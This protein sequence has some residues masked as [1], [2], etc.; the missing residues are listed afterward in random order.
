MINKNLQ[1]YIE[2]KILPRYNNFDKGHRIDHAQKVIA[3]SLI[4][5]ADYDVNIDM[6]YAI[7]AYH[8]LG[9]EHERELHHIY[10]GKIL[11]ADE[12]L[13]QW[14]NNEQ[15]EI[16]QMAVEDHRASN[17]HKPRSIYGKIV[18]E[19][20]RDISPQTIIRRTIQYG[21]KKNADADFEFH[22]NRAITHIKEKYGRNGYLKLYLHSEKNERGLEEI[23]KI[24]DDENTLR[25]MCKHFFDIEKNL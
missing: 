4:L 24:I 17:K 14:F 3:D 15:M 10:S 2:T 19:A 5:A 21:L 20:D 18:A 12:T 7:A 1:E 25:D 6:V 9:L 22:F 16:M 13:Q 11:L 23:R 8:D